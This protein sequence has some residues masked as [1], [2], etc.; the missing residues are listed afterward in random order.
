MPD[1][2][3]LAGGKVG[4]LALD[5]FLDELNRRIAAREGRE[6]Q[7]GHSFLMDGSAPLSDPAE[8]ARRFRQE[9]LPLLQEF[10]F[11]DYRVLAEYIGEKL[12]NKEAQ[13]LDEERLADPDRLLEAL[14]AAFSRRERS[15]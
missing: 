6:K 5:D 9:I 14:E 4:A 7:I 10:C 1:S 3:L 13:V 15:E 8:F 2:T 11:E 12:V